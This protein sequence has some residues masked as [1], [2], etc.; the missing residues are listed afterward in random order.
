MDEIRAASAPLGEPLAEGGVP[1]PAASEAPDFA[2]LVRAVEG[3]IERHQ[4][5]LLENEELRRELG[6]RDEQLRVLNQRRQ[7]AIKH[8][9]DLIAQI[10]Q[11]DA[12]F[13]QPS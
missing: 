2:R 5:V 9:D 1:A 12:R 13:E 8:L 11:L 10:D 7:D 6:E 3:L 4:Q